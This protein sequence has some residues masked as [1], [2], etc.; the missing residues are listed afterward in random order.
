M[1]LKIWKFI[2][3]MIDRANDEDKKIEFI[4]KLEILGIVDYLLFSDLNED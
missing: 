2:N 3:I 1:N 4:G